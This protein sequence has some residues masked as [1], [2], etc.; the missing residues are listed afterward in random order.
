M[1]EV[2][3]MNA[4]VVRNPLQEQRKRSKGMKRDLYAMD[5]DKGRNCYSYR[6]FGHLARNCKSWSTV[7]QGRRIEYE[8]NFNHRDNLKE[9]KSL[10]VLN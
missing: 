7:N 2:E 8:K 6:R 4:V 9:E 1:E 5:V 3:R 10:V